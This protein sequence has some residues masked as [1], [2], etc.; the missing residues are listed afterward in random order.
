MKIL[1]NKKGF[2]LVAD[3]NWFG[4]SV[5]YGEDFYRSDNVY[6]CHTLIIL[7]LCFR[8]RWTFYKPR[9]KNLIIDDMCDFYKEHGG[10]NCTECEDEE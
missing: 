5:F 6:I 7:F 1:I 3:K 4:I 9:H 8:A 10:E 2:T